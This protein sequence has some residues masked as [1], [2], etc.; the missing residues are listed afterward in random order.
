VLT[1]VLAATA[2]CGLDFDRF[3]PV[4]A[5]AAHD[6]GSGDDA[7][8]TPTP[9]A[10]ADAPAD[11]QP[12]GRCSPSA[13]TVVASAAL[14]AVTIDGDLGDWGSPSFTS[15]DVG[16]A[17]L[18]LGPTG[19][20][21]A[22]SATSTCLVPSS[23]SA[24]FAAMWDATH[25]YVA[26]KVSVPSVGGTNGMAPNTNDAVE[27]YLR[28]DTTPTGDYSS[29]DQQYITDWQNTVS[30][31]GVACPQRNPPGFTS[32]VSVAADH[33]GYVLEA[34]IQL[35]ELGVTAPASGT[36][37]GFDLGID[38]GQGTDATR[39]L[40]VWWKAGHAAPMCA[41]QRCRTCNPDQPYCDT[42]DV[43]LLCM[44]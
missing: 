20:C 25:L 30:G 5:S 29:L 32:A 3:A 26:V 4:D 7:T 9:D 34:R 44:D 18:I 1:L 13:G 33:T 39:S 22:A 11:A 41:S 15:F 40:L 35:S 6:E 10:F 14:G 8:S 42:L 21:D 27:L 19:T 38:H 37:V 23:E 24:Q 17:Q 28:G 2:A 36:T 16:D 43:G 12:A 31:C